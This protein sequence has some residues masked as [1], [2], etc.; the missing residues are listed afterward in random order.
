M[1]HIIGN[2]NFEELAGLEKIY[3]EKMI[4]L[5]EEEEYKDESRKIFNNYQKIFNNK[6]P[7][8]KKMKK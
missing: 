2:K 8:M 5:N 1:E 7:R 3:E 6:K 4:E